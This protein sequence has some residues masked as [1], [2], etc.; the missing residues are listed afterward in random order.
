MCIVNLL[1]LSWVC[2]SMCIWLVRLRVNCSIKYTFTLK[3]TIAD[4]HMSII[5]I[6]SE[7]LIMLV[8]VCLLSRLLSMVIASWLMSLWL[9]MFACLF[10]CHVCLCVSM[11][12]F[13]CACLCLR[14]WLFKMIPDWEHCLPLGCCGHARA[15][16]PNLSGWLIECK[17]NFTP[18]LKL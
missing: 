11:N 3:S 14:V 4:Q 7:L 16:F 13:L 15:L 9:F 8:F 1:S 10:M 18:K 6:Y 5:I 12:M 2:V 17:L